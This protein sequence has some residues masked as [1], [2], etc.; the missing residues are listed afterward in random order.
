[1]ENNSMSYSKGRRAFTLI[2]LLVVIAIIAILAAILFPVFAQAREKARATSCL[3]N[4]KQIGLGIMMYSQDYD[5]TY[6]LFYAG[7]C[8]NPSSRITNPLDATGPLRLNMWQAQIH[9][10]LKSWD[11]YACPSDGVA[12]SKDP[13][14]KFHNL[15]YGYNYGY[16]SKFTIKGIN[17]TADPAELAGGTC[18]TQWYQGVSYAAVQRPADIVMVV[19]TGGRAAFTNPSSLGSM[20]N[21]PDAAPST[22]YFYSPTAQA[23][24]GQ[25]G[26]N[27]YKGTPGAK[28]ANTGGVAW[29]HNE[30]FN[31]NYADGHAKFSKIGGMMV[32]TNNPN[33]ANDCAT[34]DFTTAGRSIQ[35]WDP[36]Y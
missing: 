2:E 6:P 27:Y 5:E 13:V 30:G 10:Y 33:L 15:S 22:E 1:M 23:G 14:I 20:V 9:P 21:P 3:S 16:L 17:G 26:D 34:T 18:S 31:V 4:M 19:D 36:R 7:N 29:R 25:N 24:W 11:I 28:W 8:T 12:T 35:K 32:G